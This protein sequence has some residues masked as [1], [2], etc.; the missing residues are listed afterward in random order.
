MTRSRTTVFVV[1]DEALISMELRDRLATLGYRVCGHADC[2]E[3]AL[4]EIPASRPDV[5]LMDIRLAGALNGIETAA[6]LREITDAP[7]IFLT[8]YS[9]DALLRE[10][11]AVEASGYIVKPFDERELDVAIQ[12]APYR[13]R[14]ERALRDANDR[15]EDRVRERTAE[16][17]ASEQMLS[18]IHANLVGSAV[19]R[20]EV[21]PAG[22]IRC[23]YISPNVK[24]LIGIESASFM[25][26]AGQIFSMV[27]PDD[28][29][30]LEIERRRMLETEEARPFELRVR[31]ADGDE[32]WFRFRSRFA[33]RR[34]D[35]TH[36]RDGLATD[37]TLD[38]RAESILR[39]REEALAFENANLEGTLDENERVF[40][41]LTTVSPVGIFRT[42]AAGQ[43]LFVN[44]RW[45]EIGG[46]S[47]EAVREA[48]WAAAIHPDD[49][50]RVVAEWNAAVRIG[51]AF[52]AEYRLQRPD[53]HST[54]VLGQGVPMGDFDGGVG[55][56]LGTITDITDQ[57]RT[58]HALRLLTT[59]RVA[60]GTNAFFESVVLGLATLLDCEAAFICRRA[61]GDQGQ[62]QSVAMVEDGHML[63]SFSYP[64]DG[65]PC[66]DVLAGRSCV[67]PSGLSR[68]YRDDAYVVG[69]QMEAYAAV[70]L[71]DQRGVT[72]GLIGIMSRSPLVHMEQVEGVLNL[73]GIS[74]AA[75]FEQQRDARRFHDMVE[76]ASDGIVMTNRDGAITLVNREAELLF[77]WTREEL[78]GQTVER[79]VPSDLGTHHVRHRA[80]FVADG[81]RRRMGSD[82]RAFVAVRKDGSHFPVEISLSPIETEDGAMVV[83][84]VRDVSEWQR[85]ER[86]ARRAQRM[87]AIG[88]LAGGIAHDLNNALAP[89]TMAL[90]LL[91]SRPDNPRMLDTMERS[92]MRAVEMVRQLLAFAK[93]VEGTHAPV[94]LRLLLQEMEAIVK[95]TFPRNINVEIRVAADTPLVVAE[96]TQLHQVLLNLCVNARDAMPGG[97]TLTLEVI[98]VDVDEVFAASMPDVAARPG[99]YVALRVTDTG[100]GIAPEVVDRMFDPF[101]TTKGFEQGSGLGLSTVLGIVKGHDGFI[102]VASQ[103]GRG[104][105]FSVY[106]P[107]GDELCVAAL[108]PADAA[109]VGTGEVVLFVDDESAVNEVAKAVLEELN[110]RV[111]LAV[112][113][114]DALV[115]AERRRSDLRVVITDLHMPRVDGLVF[116]AA[117]RRILPDIP[118]VVCSGRFDEPATRALGELGVQLFLEKPFT[119]EQLAAVLRQALQSP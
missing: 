90:S 7:V 82:R 15:L 98:P 24:E 54:W 93:G 36:V 116:V 101:F 5:V 53:G 113:G 60:R 92:A 41:A 83:A 51:A 81:R 89:I 91:R 61:P 38:K 58:E 63:N 110:V 16:L 71:N 97:G 74:V 75:E 37:I 114:A 4:L 69:K 72:F 94:D 99:R 100:T 2:G 65:T 102:Q 12:M 30:S 78:I 44:H 67:V 52:R 79:L 56:Y 77:G 103:P 48:G 43:C 88:T 13:R 66:A 18:N 57:K 111:V 32:R 39:E 84:A 35:G 23:T 25:R 19:Y 14:M 8:A 87:E 33:E 108:Q 47:A 28:L 115:Q 6:R 70:P 96:A 104:T 46:T 107:A 40:S 9:D 68:C 1:E 119:Q 42:D 106:V 86:Q 76:F 85:L 73:F 50:A 3:T 59:E 17:A 117:L 64:I 105:T 21:T 29:P 11:G 80:L 49:H 55:G 22:K 62:L 118:I 34:P 26:D 20:L 109:F 10:A 27:H 45:C 112:D 31:H 95:P